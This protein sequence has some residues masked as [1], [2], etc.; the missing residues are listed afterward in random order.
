MIVLIFNR[1]EIEVEVLF[2]G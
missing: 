2:M 1:D